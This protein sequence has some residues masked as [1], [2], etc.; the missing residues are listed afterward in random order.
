MRIAATSRTALVLS[1][2]ALVAVNLLILGLRLRSLADQ[3]DLISTTLGEGQVLYPIWKILNG[4]P[5]YEWP[6]AEHYGLTL[7]NAGFYH[8]Y[9]ALIGLAGRTDQ[10]LPHARAITVLFAGA[11]FVVFVRA[12]GALFARIHGR[13][14]AGDERLLHIGIGVLLWFGTAS[15]SWWI[16]AARPDVPG[17]VFVTAGLLI[18]LVG[19]EGRLGPLLLAALAFFVAWSFK[20]SIIGVVL[21]VLAYLALSGRMAHLAIFG[22]VYFGLIA[23]FLLSG[24]EQY[25]AS[26]IGAA[27]I[28]G[29]DFG[30]SALAYGRIWATNV[31]FLIPAAWMAREAVR[32][33]QP[34][35]WLL[36]AACLTTNALAFVTLGK[37]GAEK[38]H[39]FEALMVVALVATAA[40]HREYLVGRFRAAVVA[41][42]VIAS[43][44]GV[45]QII[46]ANR[47]GKITL[48]EPAEY[49]AKATMRSFMA[50]LPKPTYIRDEMLAVPWY[51]TDNQYPAPVIDHSN[52]R[53]A[54]LRGVVTGP[55]LLEWVEQGRFAAFVLDPRDAFVPIVSES[56]AL[57]DLPPEIAELGV[58][59]YLRRDHVAQ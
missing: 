47:L 37:Q 51:T 3:G 13:A 30:Q 29:I 49:A 8:A 46:L 55:G 19:A 11:G 2:G 16:V 10:F 48:A 7:Y 41:V 39:A 54:R 33:V 53:D 38:N 5:L 52:Y 57:A 22:A 12:A 45:A 4:H 36:L 24:S 34:A 35:S 56:Y 27:G 23:L 28:H 40:C 17:L 59:V 42:C 50:T 15:V 58:H 26:I 44:M 43:G 1:I 18:L 21:G 32:R 14:P 6:Y 20:Q 25:R 31:V 9:A